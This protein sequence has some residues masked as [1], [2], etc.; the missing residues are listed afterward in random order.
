KL[1]DFKI[2][3]LRLPRFF[4]SI[5]VENIGSDVVNSLLSSVSTLGQIQ[6]VTLA[7]GKVTIKLLINNLIK[8]KNAI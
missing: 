2:G 5:L 1:I 4:G 6:E 8:L 7:Q 3:D